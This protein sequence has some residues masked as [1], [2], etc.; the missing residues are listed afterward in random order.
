[1][2]T[3]Y[4]KRFLKDLAKVPLKSRKKIEE[5]VFIETTKLNSIEE[6][7]IIEKMTGY[8]EY[9]KI[10]FGDYRVGLKYEDEVIIFERVLHRK[11]IYKYFP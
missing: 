6:T 4:R 3:V 10:R 2:K 1:L 9:Y 7:K 8:S 5:F 11:D